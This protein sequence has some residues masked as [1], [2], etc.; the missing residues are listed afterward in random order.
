MAKRTKTQAAL[1]YLR[2]LAEDDYVQTQ[3]SEAAARLREVYARGSREGAKAAE[4]KKLYTL[5]R[6]A[7][8]SLRRA[9][10]RLEEPP[11]KPKRGARAALLMIVGAVAAAVVA[12]RARASKE[13][14]PLSQGS[15]FPQAPQPA[16]DSPPV[17]AVRADSM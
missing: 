8:T 4:D 6:E 1:P 17:Q 3:L 12:K 15:S 7:A 13:S 9:A 14:Q 16:V 11:P 10:G 5:A 2:R